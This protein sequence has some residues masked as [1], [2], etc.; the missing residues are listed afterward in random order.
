MGDETAGGDDRAGSAVAAQ[1][2]RE[3]DAAP[4]AAR[5]RLRRGGLRRARGGAARRQRGPPRRDPGPAR[6]R[7]SAGG[8]A[9]GAAG[10]GETLMRRAR[11]GPNG[12][13]LIAPATG[14]GEA[15]S[16]LMTHK[17]PGGASRRP[18]GQGI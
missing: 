10:E 7:R 8:G 2:G 18:G 1:F 12:A 11:P 17:G 6:A 9:G 13:P 14:W 4:P 3:G 15:P 5:D 16:R